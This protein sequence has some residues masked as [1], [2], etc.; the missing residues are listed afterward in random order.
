M[1]VIEEMQQR[2]LAHKRQAEYQRLL[3]HLWEIP[4]FK[5]W[6]AIFCRQCNVTRPIIAKN[7]ND[8]IWNESRRHL[9]M[10]MLQILAE[11]DLG[12]L[13]D[14]IEKQTQE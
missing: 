5:E 4:E 2:L 3:K 12:R 7:P 1:G 13:I 6:L 8:I 14:R 10:S 11:D 9:A